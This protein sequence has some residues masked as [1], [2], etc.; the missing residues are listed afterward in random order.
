[1]IQSKNLKFSYNNATKFHFPDI[2]CNQGEV[3]LITGK[4]GTGKTTLLHLLAG[5]LK[6]DDGEIK[7]NNTDITQLNEKQ[8][9]KFR[10]NNIGIVLQKAYF[11]SSLNV[12]ENIELASWLATKNKQS[13]KAKEILAQLDLTSHIYKKPSELSIGQQQRVSIARAIINQPKLILADEPTAN[14]DDDNCFNVITLLKST[15]KKINASLIIVT[16][17]NR[18]KEKHNNFIEL[19]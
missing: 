5:I 10:G 7:I 9:D 3:L 19:K 14:L 15:A 1:M 6:P 8:L 11:I 16:H 12:I 17:D 4:S 18:L 2:L 13:Q